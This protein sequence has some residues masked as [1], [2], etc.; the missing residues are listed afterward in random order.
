[1]KILFFSQENCSKNANSTGFG[2]TVTLAML[3]KSGILAPGEN[4]MSI[5]YMVFSDFI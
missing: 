3:L 2:K 5:E 4:T 1:M